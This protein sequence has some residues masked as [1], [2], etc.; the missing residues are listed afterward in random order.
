MLKNIRYY[1]KTKNNIIY[2]HTNI[3]TNIPFHSITLHYISSLHHIICIALHCIALHCMRLPKTP[4]HL[5]LDH[6]SIETHASIETHGFRYSHFRKPPC[7]CEK[8]FRFKR[9]YIIIQYNTTLHCMTS[10]HSTQPY[11][12]SNYIAT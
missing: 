12:K 5:K 8:V 4:N 3:H 11:L 2:T 7:I 10:H 6:S 9:T 1:D